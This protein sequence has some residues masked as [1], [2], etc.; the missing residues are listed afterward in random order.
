MLP[1][2]RFQAV[3]FD[4]DGVLIDS[5]PLHAEAKRR[6]FEALGLDVPDEAVTGFRGQTDEAVLAE[7][8]RRHGRPG[9]RLHA[10]I[11]AKNA[12]YESLLE[13]LDLI[14]GAAEFVTLLAGLG[15]RL[16][17]ATSATRRN[18]ELAFARFGLSTWFEIV[19]TAADVPHPKPHPD[20]YTVT[21]TLLGL[22]PARCLVIED[23][24]NGVL[25]ARAAGCPVA[26]IT[27]SFS[28]ADLQQAGADLVVPGYADLRVRLGLPV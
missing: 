27:T 24:I 17:L 5:E 2:E 10:L 16:A 22:S 3:I 13:R 15:M 7:V 1:L 20:P 23:S 14:H 18:Q 25:S 9:V 26:A 4:L 11:A 21:T 12:A 28:S 8:L 6:T 19:T